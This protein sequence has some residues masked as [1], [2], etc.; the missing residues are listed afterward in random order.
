MRQT[1]IEVGWPQPPTLIQTDNSTEAGVVNYT[2][3]ARKKIHGSEVPLIKMS[4]STTT[5]SFL[6]GPWIQQLGRLQH[7]APPAN[8]PWIKAPL[9]YRRRSYNVPSPSSTLLKHL[10]QSC[11]FF[12]WIYLFWLQQGCI[13]TILLP[14]Y[15]H[16]YRRTDPETI[17]IGERR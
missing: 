7:Q 16:V 2:I 11:I 12:I 17:E 6:L 8:L 1:L 3:I 15:L 4:W 10:I 5:I 13:V 14:Y 9:I